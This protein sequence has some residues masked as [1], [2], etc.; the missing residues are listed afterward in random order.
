MKAHQPG[1]S[2]GDSARGASSR[3]CDGVRDF[4]QLALWMAATLA[5]VVST[6]LVARGAYFRKLSRQ[7]GA[8]PS[9]GKRRE[10]ARRKPSREESLP[11]LA[12]AIVGNS[13]GAVVAVFGPPRNA[14]VC[15]SLLEGGTSLSRS[16]HETWY[17][18]L[19]QEQNL[20]MAIE[21]EHDAAR[22]V[23]FFHAPG[24]AA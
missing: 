19:K 9:P 21:F 14:V 6:V 22:H 10:I 3:M 2:E 7:V 17:Y 8:R 1:Q 4:G 23:E 15:S 5:G 13:R 20:A 18:P 16:Q 24:V 11:M 12:E